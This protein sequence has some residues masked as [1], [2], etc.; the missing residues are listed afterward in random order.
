LVNGLYTA[1]LCIAIFSALSDG[2]FF[3]TDWKYLDVQLKEDLYQKLLAS[4]IGYTAQIR[5]APDSLKVVV[6]DL[7]SDHMGSKRIKTR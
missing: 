1:S 4:G 3:S 6:C 2:V 5:G 7:Q